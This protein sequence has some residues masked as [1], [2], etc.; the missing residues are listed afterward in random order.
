MLIHISCQLLQI[1]IEVAAGGNIAAKIDRLH[2]S[3]R[4]GYFLRKRH[5]GLY[6]LQDSLVGFLNF[7]VW[8]DG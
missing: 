3:N 2:V 5:T 7:L 8:S 6:A 4:S 1:R